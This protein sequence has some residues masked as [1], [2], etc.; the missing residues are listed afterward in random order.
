MW[1]DRQH[2]DPVDQCRSQLGHAGED[3][4]APDNRVRLPLPYSYGCIHGYCREKRGCKTNGTKINS[5]RESPTHF[6][7][8]PV[9]RRARM[10]PLPDLILPVSEKEV[11]NMIRFA[12]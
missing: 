12:T 9:D 8:R 7:Q 10:G 6:A 2:R 4:Q 5:Q 3:E 11:T 1:L